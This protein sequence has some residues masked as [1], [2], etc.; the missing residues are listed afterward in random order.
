MTVVRALD[1][2]RWF[3]SLV[4]EG[5]F[6][7]LA[8]GLYAWGMTVAWP[9][10]HRLAPWP[11]RALAGV[12]LLALLLGALLARYW[13][14]SARIAGLWVFVAASLASWMLLSRAIDPSH[15]DPLHGALGSLGWAAFAVVWGGQRSIPALSE[16]APRQVPWSKARRRTLLVMSIVGTAAAVPIALAWWVQS[17][18]R[19]LLAHAVSLAAGIA[20]IVRAADV[21][22]PPKKES[23]PRLAQDRPKRRLMN[24]AWPLAILTG[25]ALTGAVLGLLR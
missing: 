13:P 11:A 16:I 10:S 21:A 1:P 12:A 20:L 19:A 22:A 9:A 24:A 6:D 2:S 5:F 23:G 3:A 8:P 17:V 14:S 7:L 18:E 25:L 15:L 4:R